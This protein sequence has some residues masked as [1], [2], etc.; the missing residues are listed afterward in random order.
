MRKVPR[1]PTR[2][3]KEK[4][5]ISENGA[6][7]IRPMKLKSRIKQASRASIVGSHH[8]KTDLKETVGPN[9]RA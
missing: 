7:M 2:F 6:G 9:I 3:R 4:V 5:D 8:T 1:L